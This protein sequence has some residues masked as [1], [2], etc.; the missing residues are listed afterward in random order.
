MYIIVVEV[1]FWIFEGKLIIQKIIV[2]IILNKINDFKL[3]F[4]DFGS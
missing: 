1:F 2:T 4:I 3:L